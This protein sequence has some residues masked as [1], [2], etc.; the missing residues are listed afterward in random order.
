MIVLARASRKLRQAELAPRVGITQ[1][2]LSKIEK[3]E[4]PVNDEVLKK[5]C[6]VLKYTPNFFCQAGSQIPPVLSYRRRDKV[7]Q[8]I[9]SYIDAVVNVRRIAIQ[10]LLS[11]SEAK[12]VSIPVIEVNA[13]R[14]PQKIAREVRKQWSV[15]DG[16]LG[17]LTR[18]LEKHAVIILRM[19]FE[20]EH[21]LSRTIL[22]EDNH[23]VIVYNKNLLAD[24]LRFTLAHELGHLVMHAFCHVDAERNI[25][26]EAN[27]FAAEF[28]M[29]ERDISEQLKDIKALKKIDVIVPALGQLKQKW[30]VSMQALVY[31]ANDLGLIEENRKN[32]LIGSFKKMGIKKREPKEFDF[33]ME[34]PEYFSKI[35]NNYKK[36]NRLD[37]NDLMKWLGL[38][39]T[40]F[41][42]LLSNG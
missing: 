30:G 38:S 3:N 42:L 18:L 35:V 2:T 26:H 14:S 34:N 10:S 6:K 9:V 8:A 1:G 32:V 39:E 41:Q 21:L 33:Q 16:P 17:N 29:P 12:P 15:P 37:D 24:Q 11:G 22:T 31:R 40:D 36:I 5:I 7:S 25:I 13:K 23:P 28:L 4:L 27:L 20:T 19:D